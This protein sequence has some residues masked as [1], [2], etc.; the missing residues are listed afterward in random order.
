MEKQRMI[1][2][3]R[4]MRDFLEVLAE[5]ITADCY[6]SHVKPTPNAQTG[7]VEQAL[8]TTFKSSNKP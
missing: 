3:T 1:G 8:W 2:K 6:I 7:L 4:S 5:M